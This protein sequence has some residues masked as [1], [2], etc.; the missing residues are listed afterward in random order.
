[1]RQIKQLRVHE[2]YIPGEER[3]DIALLKLDQ[4][5]VCSHYVQLGCVPD[6]TLKV[7]ELKTCYIAGWSSTATRGEFPKRTHALRANLAHQGDALGFPTAQAK[8]RVRLQN[9]CLWRDSPRPLSKTRQKGESRPTWY[10][11]GNPMEARGKGFT[12]QWEGG[13]WPRNCLMLISFCAH[14]SE[15]K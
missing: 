6:T 8:A 4:P 2:H 1:M 13:K 7:S 9:V 10:L 14:R 15:T 5:V 11:P 12:S 3:N